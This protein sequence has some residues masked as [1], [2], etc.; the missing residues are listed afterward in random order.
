MLVLLVMLR[1]LCIRVAST[2]SRIDLKRIWNSNPSITTC[3]HEV[4]T[5]V[6]WLYQ[7]RKLSI[8][9]KQFFFSSFYLRF[10]YPISH[11]LFDEHQFRFTCILVSMICT[12]VCRA[13]YMVELERQYNPSDV[14]NRLHLN[15]L[16]DWLNVGPFL[17]PTSSKKNSG[18]SCAT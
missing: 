4:L 12:S 3:K 10:L 5:H 7:E 8:T 18:K 14:V 16:L 11:V 6:N 1:W 15:C 13:L 9:L 17:S 2:H